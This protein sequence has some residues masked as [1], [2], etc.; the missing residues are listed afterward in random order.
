M[1][2]PRLASHSSQ[3]RIG[4][5]TFVARRDQT[6]REEDDGD[7]DL[8]KT[9]S[10]SSVP[11]TQDFNTLNVPKSEN[12]DPPDRQTKLKRKWKS[13]VLVCKRH[14]AFLGPGLV[15]AVVG[16]LICWLRG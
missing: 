15:A 6:V 8:V 4:Y 7:R 9:A 1:Q 11:S 13:L 3:N 16:A 2:G 10:N 12:D 14:I 5:N